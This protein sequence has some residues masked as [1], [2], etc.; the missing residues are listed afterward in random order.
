[1]DFYETLQKH[2][3]Y[4]DFTAREVSDDILSRVIG[5]AFKAPD[6]QS[7]ASARICRCPRP[8]EDSRNSG[9]A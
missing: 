8:D 9:P 7:S 1:M 4:R 6:K 3:T 2:R 5:V